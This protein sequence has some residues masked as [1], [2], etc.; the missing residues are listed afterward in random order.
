M[1]FNLSHPIFI[2]LIGS[3]FI[4]NLWRLEIAKYKLLNTCIIFEYVFSCYELMKK[5]VICYIKSIYIYIHI[6]FIYT[7]T[8]I[9]LQQEKK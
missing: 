3:W 5:S 4:Y 2:Y 9:I 7:Y 1:Y 6:I 8:Q